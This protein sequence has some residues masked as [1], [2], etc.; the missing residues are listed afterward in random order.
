MQE[1]TIKFLPDGIS[2]NI[3]E[4]L[5]LLDAAREANIDLNASCGGSGNCDK[6]LVI[7]A[8]SNV[9]VR[10]CQ[11]YPDHS[12]TVNIPDTSRRNRIMK[13]LDHG[14]NINTEIQLSPELRTVKI[15]LVAPDMHD[16]SSDTKRL[17]HTV[18]HALELEHAQVSVSYSLIK[19][20]PDIL[21]LYIY[22]NQDTFNA[23]AVI[24]SNNKII[25]LRP[26]SGSGAKQKLYGIAIDLGTTTIAAALV[27]LTTGDILDRSSAS[28]PQIAH[29]D[30]VISRINYT[31]EYENGL[32]TLHD[33]II[34]AINKLTGTLARNNLIDLMD[35]FEI[36][37]VGNATM[38][39]ILANVPVTQIGQ[40]PYVSAFCQ[41]LTLPADTTNLIINPNGQMIVAP[42]VAGHV[43]GDTL[44]VALASEMEYNSGV[45]L[46]VDIGTNGE[47]VLAHD[48]NLSCCS[49]A[50][51]P[52]FEG[53]KIH[54]GTRA[55]SGAIEKFT[56]SD[57]KGFTTHTIG[58][59]LPTGICGS[60]LID[61]LACLLDYGII[62]ETGRMLTA[63]EL[64]ENT[65]AQFIQRLST[66]NDQPAFI[67]TPDIDSGRGEPILLT[68]KDVRETQL[69]KA[70]IAAGIEI[71]LNQ[72]NLELDS[73]D[74]VYMAG[75]FGNYL[76]PQSAKRV[77]LFPP[78]DMEKI[79]SIGN[80]AGTG[81]IA[82]LV[83]KSQRSHCQT[84]ANII[85]YTELAAHS[86][87]QMI[88][89]DKMFF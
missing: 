79:I 43:G 14:L 48:G 68:Q 38:Q 86:E 26:L 32:K 62:D 2:V 61:I 72:A 59:V 11:F 9:P 81:A 85:T 57:D 19:A 18:A 21:R 12:M 13:V 58:D 52:A 23:Y 37:V 69:G 5:T 33:L 54:H 10:A 6:C 63:D 34:K 30:D 50:A 25:G 67:I 24:D 88:F 87:F 8:G 15:K 75:A 64:P 1:Y 39:H 22:D 60:G 66:Y 27:D 29:G 20:L 44:A 40:A 49:T 56:F 84:L 74:R 47:I 36:V 51:G 17:I 42:G 7:P 35:I 46:A 53:A 55:T 70:A 16:L 82:M 28:N 71:L 41:M 78:V 4:G 76:H 80:A 83:N 31:S 89:A 77:G 65:P 3:I 73:I 45:T